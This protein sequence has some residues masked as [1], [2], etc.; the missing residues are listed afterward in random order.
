MSSNHKLIVVGDGGVGKSAITLQ[1]MYEEFVEDYEPT[2]AD[3][4]RKKM[5]LDGSDC[6][7]DI[8]D[9]AGQ[10]SHFLVVVQKD[11]KSGR[12]KMVASILNIHTHIHTTDTRSTYIHSYIHSFIHTYIQTDIHTLTRIHT[13]LYSLL[14]GLCSHSRQ[15][16]SHRRGV[17]VCVFIDR[18][19]NL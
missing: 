18:D 13:L 1:Y 16:L 6:Q 9:T 19:K 4:Y 11:E 15:L 8:L 5:T 10:V 2:K 3:T 17:S 12:F 14:G 7:I